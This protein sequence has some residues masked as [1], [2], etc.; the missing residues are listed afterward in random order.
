MIISAP[1]R[2]SLSPELSSPTCHVID[3][4][5]ISRRYLRESTVSIS[6]VTCSRPLFPTTCPSHHH[7]F[8]S[9]QEANGKREIYA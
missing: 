2:N 9:K 1:L 7:A 4:S 5:D 8:R 3:T 6:G